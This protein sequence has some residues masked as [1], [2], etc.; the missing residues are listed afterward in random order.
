MK[1]IFVNSNI[2]ENHKA[3]K[4][5]ITIISV[6]LLINDFIITIRKLQAILV[7]TYINFKKRAIYNNIYTTHI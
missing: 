7:T 4:K 3:R 2:I 5:K 6:Y 1:I